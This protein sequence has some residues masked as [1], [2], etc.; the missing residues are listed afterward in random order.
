VVKNLDTNVEVALTTNNSGV[1]QASELVPG[2]YSVRVEARGFNPVE[3]TNVRVTANSTITTDVQMKLGTTSQTVSVTAE[4]PV[5][6]D[7]PSNFTTASLESRAINDLPLVGRDI[8]NLVQLVPGITQSSGPSGSVFGFNSQFG[9]FPDPLHLV[10]STVSA[11]GSQGGANAW[12]LDGSVNA[13]LGA[14]NAVVVPSQDAVEEFAVVNNGLAPEWG[15]TSG[16]IFNIVL[17]SGTN[18]IHGNVYEFNRNSTFSATNPFARRDPSGRPFLQPRV[19]FNNFGGTLGGPVILP[20]VYNG[21]NHTFFFVSY[22]ASLLHETIGRIL[23]VPIGQERFG[24]FRGDPRFAANCDPAHGVTN[25]IYDPYSTTGPDANGLYHRT[26]FPTPQIPQSRI[27]PLASFYASSY[28]SP[29]FVDPLQ[30]G[31]GGCG[32]FCNNF[33]GSARSSQTTHNVSIKLDHSFSESEKFF[34]EWLYNPTDYTNLQYPWNGPTAQT[35]TGVAAAQPY[36][37]RNQIA[38]IG[39]TSSITPTLVNEAR[40]MFSRQAQVATPNPDSVVGN[41]EVLQHVQGKNFLLFAPYQV[42]PDVNIGDVGGFGPQQ[43]QNAIQGVQAYTFIDNVTKIVGRHTLK[44][45]MM[46]RRDNNWNIAAWG[47][48]LGFGGGLTSDPVSGLGGSGLAQFL[49][50]AVDAGSG[51]GNYHAPWQ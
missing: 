50:G 45:G 48:G 42:V 3:V 28:P 36:Q 43:W 9:G 41:N 16:A 39:L 33:I 13:A 31:E 4:A 21:K 8:Q 35:Q 27:D 34:F 17:K 5:V 46:W 18:R 14:E 40:F 11:N 20:K 15:R 7:T 2:R 26:P 6:E 38:A 30:Q 22:E 44:G 23:T 12:Y 25:C 51:T 10:G 29:N 49:L 32:I 37:T 1:Y 24:D 47:Y 19:N